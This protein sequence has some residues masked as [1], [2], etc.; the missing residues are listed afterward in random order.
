FR[1][2]EKR[3]RLKRCLFL[4]RGIRSSTSS[5][6]KSQPHEWPDP[7]VQWPSLDVLRNRAPQ[8]P[9]GAWPHAWLPAP[10]ECADAALVRAQALLQGQRAREAREPSVRRPQPEKRA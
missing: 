5:I 1:I 3:Q 8:I 7:D 6:R 2:K 10:R 9:G 4:V